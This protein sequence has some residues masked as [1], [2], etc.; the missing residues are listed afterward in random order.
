MTRVLPFAVL[1]ACAN[2]VS[3]SDRS[4]ERVVS[5]SIEDE[6]IVGWVGDKEFFLSEVPLS[7][8]LHLTVDQWDTVYVFQEERDY[9]FDA[10]RNS[11]YL[12]DFIPEEGSVVTVDYLPAI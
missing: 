2:T 8:S 11:I 5:E 1:C 4:P 3:V 10:R 6:W 12:W 9:S 7:G